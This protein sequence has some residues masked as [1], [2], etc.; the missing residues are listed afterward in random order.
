MGK[1]THEVGKKHNN[2]LGIYDMSGNV[3]E[4][5]FDWYNSLKEESITDPIGD[6]ISESK[7]G[8]GGSWFSQAYFCSVSFRYFNSP[9]NIRDYLGFRVVRSSTK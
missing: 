4:W 7:V 5:C 1:G 2:A 3:F 8:R 6:T 9:C